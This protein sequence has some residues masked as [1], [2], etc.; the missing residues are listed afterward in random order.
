LGDIASGV[1]NPTGSLAIKR[2]E[3]RVSVDHDLK[4]IKGRA[5]NPEDLNLVAK[6]FA[7]AL[8]N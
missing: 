1:A 6:L 7:N 3:K 8:A 2:L 5:S 4:K